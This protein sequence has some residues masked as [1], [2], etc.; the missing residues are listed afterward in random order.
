MAYNQ[1]HKKLITYFIERCAVHYIDT[2]IKHKVDNGVGDL[3]VDN[4]P[5]SRTVTFKYKGCCYSFEIPYGHNQLRFVSL[6][7]KK[8]KIVIVGKNVKLI[9]LLEYKLLQVIY[10]KSKKQYTAN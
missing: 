10:E 9:N 1:I 7:M 5:Y 2:L 3:F 6:A 8:T 4:N